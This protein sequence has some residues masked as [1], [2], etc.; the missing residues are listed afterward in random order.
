[1]YNMAPGVGIASG[2]LSKSLMNL[3]RDMSIPR[4]RC[5]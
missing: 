4:A 5:S 1:L 2:F 3:V